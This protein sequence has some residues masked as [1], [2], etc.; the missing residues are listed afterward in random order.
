[1]TR[2]GKNDTAI[3]AIQS[4]GKICQTILYINQYYE[5]NLTTGVV[6]TSYYLGGQLVAAREGTTLRYIHQDSLSSTSVMSTSTGTLDSSMTFYP[7]GATR[8]GSVNTT[9]KF[10]G[11]RLDGTGLYYYGARYYDAT[12]GKFISADIIIQ[13]PTNPQ[14]LNRYTYCSNN[15]LRYTDPTG[16]DYIS[17]HGG[18]INNVT[19]VD[20]VVPI[21]KSSFTIT[22]GLVPYDS[23]WT[24]Y[25]NSFAAMAYFLGSGVA[26]KDSGLSQS[27]YPSTVDITG[28][29]T[30]YHTSSG[31]NGV[32][33]DISSSANI[34]YN[35]TLNWTYENGN[36]GGLRWIPLGRTME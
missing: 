3:N 6:T 18:A 7:F 13:N 31:L 16:K 27:D 29:V 33:C 14:S 1:M 36:S 12:I 4:R 15:P 22:S 30:A 34:G 19:I 9:K 26:I 25:V 8:T 17:D 32:T 28:N 21:E 10:T 2:G 23:T 11:Q 24:K 20:K 35:V 5:K